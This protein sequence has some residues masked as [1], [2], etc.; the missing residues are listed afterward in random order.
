MT[1]A[2]ITWLAAVAVSFAVLES[3]ALATP[4]AGDTLSENV[5]RWLGIAPVRPWRRWGVAGFLATLVGFTV[6]FGPHIVLSIW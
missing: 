1:G 4:R 3:I 5:R 2:W 6:W